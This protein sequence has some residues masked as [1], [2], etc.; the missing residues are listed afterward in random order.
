MRILH[1]ASPNLG[2]IEAYIFNHYKYMDQDRFRFDFMTQNRSLRD[3]E[4]YRDFRF[5]VKLLPATA[6]KD[7]EGFTRQVR[8][9]LSEGYDVL[10]LHTCYWTGFLI[11]KIAKEVGI[12]KVIVHSHSSFID[13]NDAG[14]RQILLER[15]EEVKRAF[16]PDLATDYWACSWNA[17]DWLFGE[18]ISRNK[19]KIMRNA[20]ESKR[21]RFN[22]EARKRIRAEL[23]LQNNL[24]LGT[25]GRLTFS[26]NHEFLINLFFEFQ[27]VNPTAR[28]L[29]IGD[30]ELRQTLRRQIYENG[31]ENKVLLLGWKPNVEDYLSAVDIFLLPSRFEGNPIS[32]IE[33]TASGLPAVIANTVTEEAVLTETIQRIPVDIPMWNLAITRLASIK[34]RREDG[35]EVV[36]NAGYD[37]EQQ[38]KV[39]EVMYGS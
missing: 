22:P 20:I 7:P 19:I 10:H 12:K 8:K 29:I 1:L 18:Q 31:L 14:K 5:H 3:A 26:K 33:A 32:L 35:I 23:C 38:A 28:L 11:E 17:A 13:E 2:G 27:K 24:I 16:S 25:V 37:V 39:L 30:G 36:R 4:E 21:F 6:A 34:S 15:H 9:I